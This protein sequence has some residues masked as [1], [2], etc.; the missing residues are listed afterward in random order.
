MQGDYFRRYYRV[1]W[2]TFQ[3]ILTRISPMI[4]K[5]DVFA[6]RGCITSEIRLACVLRWLAGG[7]HLDITSVHGISSTAFWDAVD[8]ILDSINTGFD[9]SFPFND[10]LEMQKIAHG[11]ANLHAS[12]LF[13][14]C[15]GA[16]DGMLLQIQ[17]PASSDTQTPSR[18]WCR[19]GFYAL[20]VQGV[21]DS[22]MRFVYV[23]INAPGSVH[24]CAAW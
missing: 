12:P 10:D 14:H 15:V 19:K 8:L 9:I 2:N 4:D 13:H 22:T 3:V 20:N 17:S 18:F 21:C 11:F 24:D 6:S 5:A 7:S 23:G 1:S 16:V